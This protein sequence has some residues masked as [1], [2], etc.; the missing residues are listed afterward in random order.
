MEVSDLRLDG[1][2]LIRPRVFRDSRG[3]F[4]ESY[5]AP[6]YR[7]CGIEAEFVQDNHSRSVLGTLR[8]LHYQSSPG[9]AK[10]VRV[11]VG[12]VWDVV[13]DIRPASPTFGQWEGVYL[14]ADEHLQLFV[15]IGFAHGFCVV[16]EFAEMLYKVTSP[17]DPHTECSI[18][19]DDPELGLPWPVPEPV[20]SQRDRQAESFAQFRARVKP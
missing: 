2:K 18:R 19:Y 1:L 7:A 6:R 12:R 3:F 17:Y 10:L 5:H 9:Q 8:G 4:L 11:G 13:V 14:D 16:S 20:L 15:P